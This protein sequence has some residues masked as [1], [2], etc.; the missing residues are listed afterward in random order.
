MHLADELVH[1][2]LSGCYKFHVDVQIDGLFV[3][4]GVIGIV[5]KLGGQILKSEGLISLKFVLEIFQGLSGQ[6]EKPVGTKL[7]VSEGN[8]RN[9]SW[10]GG[11]T[12][13]TVENQEEHLEVLRLQVCTVNF[14]SGHTRIL[15]VDWGH[16]W[17]YQDIVIVVL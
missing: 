11:P 13:G 3:F 17:G 1:F 7:H 2:S 12:E 8:L 4:E 9:V 10:N 14:E 6:S 16:T 5:A 15:T